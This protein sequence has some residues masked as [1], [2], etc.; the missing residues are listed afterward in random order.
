[1]LLMATRRFD[2]ALDGLEALLADPTVH[3][4]TLL[5]PLTDYLVVSLR[6]KGDYERPVRVLERFAA[7]RDVWQK[8]RLDV[9]SWVNALPELARRTAGKPSVAK[10]RQLV[11]MGDQLDVEPGDQGSRAHL[12]AASA[13]LERF[14]AEHTERDAA[15]AEAYYLR[16]IVEARIG[17]NY[18]VTAAPFLLAE[19]VRI[20]PASEPAAR[21]Y[22]LLERE[23]ILGYEGSDIE[24]LTPEDREHLDSLRALMPN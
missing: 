13:V 10:A 24:E 17:R 22:A 12:V 2:E 20:A 9:Q 3:A 18:W 7:R 11:A 5:G 8:L 21:A 1:T 4:A 19:A 15:L 14:I 16:G 6:V 23:L